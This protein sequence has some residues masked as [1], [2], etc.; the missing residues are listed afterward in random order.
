MS[1]ALL[2]SEI[3]FKKKPTVCR[4]STCSFTEG[5]QNMGC[6]LAAPPVPDR[7]WVASRWCLRENQPMAGP[8]PNLCLI[9]PAEGMQSLL[10]QKWQVLEEASGKLPERLL[11]GTVQTVMRLTHQQ[12][13]T[14]VL[15]PRVL[16]L[17]RQV[18]HGLKTRPLKADT[19]LILSGRL[20]GDRRKQHGTAH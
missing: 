19:A 11:H 12:A 13:D 20:P 5:L 16:E 10:G 1:V 8:L 7:F 14:E 15:S 17:V 18:L 4:L 9:L 3:F 6:V 2:G